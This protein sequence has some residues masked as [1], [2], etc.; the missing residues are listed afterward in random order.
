MKGHDS[1]F[2]GGKATL[3]GLYDCGPR[4]TVLC[5]SPSANPDLERI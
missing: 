1:F 2:D 3:R 5:D 4:Y